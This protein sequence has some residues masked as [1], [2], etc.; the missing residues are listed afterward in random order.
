MANSADEA[1]SDM[2][3]T[4]ALV[5]AM[6]VGLELACNFTDHGRVAHRRTSDDSDTPTGD[7]AYDSI[8]PAAEP[9]L[10]TGVKDLI[11][12]WVPAMRKHKFAS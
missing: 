4:D 1:R 10:N 12:E 9:V 7:I 6:R 11:C 8:L 3:I 5:S 2:E